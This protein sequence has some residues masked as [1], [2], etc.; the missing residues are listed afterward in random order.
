MPYVGS[1][2]RLG[3]AKIRQKSKDV[4]PSFQMLGQLCFAQTTSPS[5]LKHNAPVTYMLCN[6]P[7]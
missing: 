7:L 1:G 5:A 3:S 4:S 6:H 2:F